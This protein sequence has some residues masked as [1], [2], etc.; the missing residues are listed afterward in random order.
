[1]FLVRL[2][3]LKNLNSNFE[4][5]FG[6]AWD[7]GLTRFTGRIM[8]PIRIYDPG[9]TFEKELWE[10]KLHEYL[11]N[12]PGRREKRYREERDEMLKRP[13]FVPE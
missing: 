12:R 7:N 8:I 4:N 1:M 2:Q 11:R 10:A 13:P 5:D 9:P 6:I 3:Y